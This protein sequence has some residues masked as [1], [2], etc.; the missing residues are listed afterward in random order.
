MTNVGKILMVLIS[1]AS[2]STSK[3]PETFHRKSSKNKLHKHIIV[4]GLGVPGLIEIGKTVKENH[5]TIG[6]GTKGKEYNWG[7]CVRIKGHKWDRYIAYSNYGIRAYIDRYDFSKGKKHLVNWIDFDS[8]FVGELSNGIKI[9]KTTR[10]EVYR[11]YGENEA[12]N[13]NIEHYDS[14]GLSFEFDSHSIPGNIDDKL[15][16]IS[17]FPLKKIEE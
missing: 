3:T 8:T 5:A 11:F 6:K 1:L 13:S 12:H 16:K 10:K 15:I 17:V 2:L 14:I 7:G 9:G 4:P